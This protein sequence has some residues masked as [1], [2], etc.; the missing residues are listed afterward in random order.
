MKILF[1]VTMLF[2]FSA[3]LNAQTASHV[4]ISEVSPMKGASSVFDTGEFIELYN[5]SPTDITFGA[6]V[7]IVSGNVSG[8]NAAEWTASLSGK[9]IKAYGFL[10]IGDGGVVGRDVNFPTSKNLANSGTRSC[11]QLRDGITVV[12]A[13]GWDPALAPLLT[14]EGNR[15]QPSSTS[16]DGKSFERKSSGTA[17]APDTLGNAWDTNDNATDF[18][19]NATL[20]NNPQNSASKIEKHPFQTSGSG[21]GKISIKPASVEKGRIFDLEMVFIGDAIDSLHIVIP[22]DFIWTKLESHVRFQGGGTFSNIP[23]IAF[24]GDSIFIGNLSMKLTDSLYIFIDAVKASDSLK[25]YSIG[26]KSAVKGQTPIPIPIQPFITV[27]R[28]TPIV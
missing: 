1:R 3:L 15:F 20:A 27:Y 21:T 5:P 12:D 19:Q 25:A 22:K 6:N 17:L 16:A 26:V 14:P 24:S 8:T 4:M 18:F 2:I 10:L 7:Q 11:V 28:I 9:L 23:T 13:F